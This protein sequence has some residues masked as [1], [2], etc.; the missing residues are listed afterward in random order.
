MLPALERR[1][2]KEEIEAS[3]ER[4]GAVVGL[5]N[6]LQAAGCVVGDWGTWR[7]RDQPP[8]TATEFL[9]STA[10]PNLFKR[11]FDGFPSLQI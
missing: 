1:L 3:R 11:D 4:F 5:A 9:K 8:K 6:Q 2:T 7:S 10:T